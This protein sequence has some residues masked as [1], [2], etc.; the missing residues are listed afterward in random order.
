MLLRIVDARDGDQRVLEMVVEGLEPP[1]G[2]LRRPSLT[3]EA[4]RRD[5]AAGFQRVGQPIAT[6]SIE[7][8]VAVEAA[9]TGRLAAKPG[10]PWL[11]SA[12]PSF[13]QLGHRGL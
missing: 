4:F 11:H 5:L 12:I 8:L 2:P 6:R 1:G 7:H 3:W 9:R 10:P 13:R